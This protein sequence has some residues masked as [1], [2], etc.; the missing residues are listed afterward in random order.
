LKTLLRILSVS[1][2][3]SKRNKTAAS[4]LMGVPLSLER[5]G[6]DGKFYRAVELI[7]QRD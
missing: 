4:E 6:V 5:M 7:T 1:L 3:S 2:G